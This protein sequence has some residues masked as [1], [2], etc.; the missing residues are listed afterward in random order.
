MFCTLF[1]SLFYVLV[2]CTHKRVLILGLELGCR[3]CLNFLQLQK[4]K[5]NYLITLMQ[6]YDN[7][8][9][10][11]K[12]FLRTTDRESA[13]SE[14]DESFEEYQDEFRTSRKQS[15]IKDKLSELDD[16]ANDEFFYKSLKKSIPILD[17]QIKDDVEVFDTEAMEREAKG[18]VD[19]TPNVNNSVEFVHDTPS[20]SIQ[21]L[22]ESL[23]R[24]EDPKEIIRQ[25]ERRLNARVEKHV[26]GK[27]SEETATTTDFQR[28]AFIA[29]VT[30]I[31]QRHHGNKYKGN[32]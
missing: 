18:A 1:L 28:N 7:D 29:E 9:S 17:K 15:S 12:R 3:N 20:N 14:S 19:A 8:L 32:N 25:F 10:P 27:S 30:Q 11:K 6:I 2:V 24:N 22:R 16:L 31:V 5:Y 4:S 26:V 13:S 23:R 21:R